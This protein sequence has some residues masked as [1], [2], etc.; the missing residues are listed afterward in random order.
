MSEMTCP[1]YPGLGGSG[2]WLITGIQCAIFG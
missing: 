1:I 2:L